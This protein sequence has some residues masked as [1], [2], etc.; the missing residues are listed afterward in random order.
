MSKEHRSLMMRANR[1]M[2][3]AFVEHNLVKIEDLDGANERLLK[4]VAQG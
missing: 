1:L 2:G 4:I 3:A